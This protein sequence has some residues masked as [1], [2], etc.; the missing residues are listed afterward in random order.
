LLS[1]KIFKFNPKYFQ[2]LPF[3]SLKS[4]SFTPGV[5]YRFQYLVKDVYVKRTFINLTCIILIKIQYIGKNKTVTTN[6]S[7]SSYK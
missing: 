3:E 1:E 7:I 2:E 4:L 6:E 5:I